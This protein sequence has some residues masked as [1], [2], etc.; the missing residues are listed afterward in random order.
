MYHFGWAGPKQENDNMDLLA[1][2]ANSPLVDVSML[3]WNAI[4]QEVHGNTDTNPEGKR[5]AFWDSVVKLTGK[6]LPNTNQLLG[7]CVAAGTEMGIEYLLADEIVREGDLEAYR[8]VYRPWIYGIGRVYIG[9]N[10]IRGDGSLLSW[11]M[12]GLKEYGVLAEDE[13]GIPPYSTSTGRQWGS[14]AAALNPWK[15]K[16][17]SQSI[18]EFVE[19]TSF[20]DLAKCVIIG[21]MFP[22]IASSQ[23]FQMELRHDRTQNCSY[24][25]PS[26]T[27]MHLM[28]IPAVDFRSKNPRLYVGNQWGYSAHRGQLDGP[29]GGGWVSAEFFDKWVRKSDTSCMAFKKFNA[30]K[31]KRPSFNMID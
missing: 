9:K 12:E 27:W 11:Q 14:S 3:D 30:W 21:H 19:I 5:F 28:H 17:A 20:A 25:V 8:P 29:D 18:D 31:L 26:G 16:A 7:D 24:F 23:G 2:Q 10:R 1:S 22:V 4:S 6:H 13:V 15:E